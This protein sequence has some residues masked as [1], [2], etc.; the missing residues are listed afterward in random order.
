[1]KNFKLS[2]MLKVMNC[3]ALALVVMGAQQA[4]YWFYHQPEM[5][6]EAEAFRKYK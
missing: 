2:G 5:P 6:E 1:M 4:C 3:L